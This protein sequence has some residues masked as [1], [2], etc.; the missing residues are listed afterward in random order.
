MYLTPTGNKSTD[1]N[2]TRSRLA[3]RF[4]GAPSKAYNE[5]CDSDSDFSSRKKKKHRKCYDI[6]N[7][8]IAEFRLPEDVPTNERMEAMKE[9]RGEWSAFTDRLNKVQIG[10]TLFPEATS[11]A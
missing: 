4:A 3:D 1:D 11:N 9:I 10:R 8:S 6:D 2:S 5:R 7:M